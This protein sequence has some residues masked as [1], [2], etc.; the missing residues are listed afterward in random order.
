MLNICNLTKSYPRRGTVLDSI[1]L[2]VNSGDTVA[3][4]GPSGSG[5]STLLNLIGLLD[6]PD[7]GEIIFMDRKINGFDSNE[8]ASYRNINIGFV[9]QDHLLL[10]HLT[11]GE[12]ILLPL[13][14]GK[15]GIDTHDRD[16]LSEL[17]EETGISHLLGKMP[18]EVSGGEAQRAALVRALIN[19]PSIILA[20]EPTGSLDLQ[21]AGVIASL[22]VKMN[23]KSGTTFI[24][25]THS[26]LLAEK[27]SIHFR[28][29]SGHLIEY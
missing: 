8:A 3:V 29:E 9:F 23:K 5:K 25:V 26:A 10:P 14:A 4:T 27:M 2:F 13:L 1:N 18:S 22:F 12:N 21:N 28:L 20:D 11:I 17:G 24:T 16:Y 19:R 15:K 6:T 7:S